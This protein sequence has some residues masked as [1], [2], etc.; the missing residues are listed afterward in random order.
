MEIILYTT[1]CPKCKVLEAKLN[2]K[3]IPYEE[4]TDVDK[5]QSLGMMSAPTLSVDGKLLQFKEA[6]D[7][8]NAYGGEP[9]EN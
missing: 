5:M 8:I 6:V 2:L 1:H 4:C 3:D 9:I 7:W